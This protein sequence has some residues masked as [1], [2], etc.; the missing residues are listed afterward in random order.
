MRAKSTALTAGMGNPV[1]STVEMIAATVVSLL[2]LLAPLL[3]IAL[4]ALFC[5]IMLRAVRR[6]LRND[7]ARQNKPNGQ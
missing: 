7:A 4:V 5:W 1:I 2:A 3:A 6:L